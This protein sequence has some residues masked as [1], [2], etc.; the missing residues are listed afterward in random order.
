MLVC[1]V[2]RPAVAGQKSVVCYLDGA[3]VEQEVVAAGGYLEFPLPDGLKPGTLRVKPLAGGSVL[4]VELVPAE[5]DRRRAQEI[6]RLEERKGALQDRMQALSRR[7]EIFSAA[8]KMQSGKGPRKTKSNPDPLVSLQ[9]GTE[10]AL[11]QLE[12]VYRSERKCRGELESLERELSAARK[13]ASL[14]RIWFAGSRVRLSYL[15]ESGRWTPC[16]DFRWSPDGSGELLLH[17]RLPNPEKGASYLV[18]NGTISQGAP[19]QPVRGDYP[20]VARRTLTLKNSGRTELPPLNFVFAAL[21]PGLPP[22]EAS[23]F[24][25]GEYLGSGRFAGSGST[26]LSVGRE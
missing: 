1:L 7:E 6:A 3:R 23:A 18:S 21:E 5:R 4:R 15:V 24:W 17:A 14:A 12:S 9:R 20:T 19:P 10:F 13:G 11:A 25:Q 8:A 2:C 22:G 26:E 16:Y